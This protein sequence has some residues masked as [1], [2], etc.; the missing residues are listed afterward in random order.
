[1]SELELDTDAMTEDELLA[2]EADGSTC[3]GWAFNFAAQ[4]DDAV[5]IDV[6]LENGAAHCAVHDR[7]RDIVIDKTIGQFDLGP[8]LGAWDGD[9]HPYAADF[10]EVRT[11][12]SEG[13]FAAFYGDMA[14]SPFIV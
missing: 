3:N 5:V 9:E 10:E 2:H 12:E 14:G 8:E 13:E 11:W 7:E 1:M 4:L 6:L